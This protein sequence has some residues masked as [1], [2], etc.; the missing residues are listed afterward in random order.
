[1]LFADIDQPHEPILASGLLLFKSCSSSSPTAVVKVQPGMNSAPLAILIWINA[2][3]YRLI[4]KLLIAI[5][6]LRRK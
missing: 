6:G 5:A 3:R 1:M 4:K 2:L